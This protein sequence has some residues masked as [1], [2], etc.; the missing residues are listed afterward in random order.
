MKFNKHFN[1]KSKVLEIGCSDGVNLDALK[2]LE[3][4][5]IYGVDISIELL[6]KNSGHK[7]VCSDIFRLGIKEN[8]FDEIYCKGVL[9]HLDIGGVFVEL[10]RILRQGG[11]I[12]I[13]E[14]WPTFGRKVADFLTMNGLGRISKTFY[15][16]KVILTCEKEMLSGW[17]ESYKTKLF[18]E[19][20]THGFNIIFSKTSLINLYITIQKEE[21]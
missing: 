14:P 20:A 17:L 11:V 4:E 7:C 3:F 8:S 5:N 13:V 2:S 19:I 21:N 9:H 12:H 15:Y 1:R 6:A 10:K 18:Q 16:R